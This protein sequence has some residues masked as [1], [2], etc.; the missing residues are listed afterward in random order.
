MG[1]KAI[2]FIGDQLK[3][4]LT[5]SEN[6]KELIHQL[7]SP[8]DAF[9]LCTN[10]KSNSR[11]FLYIAK[12]LLHAQKMYDTACQL[13]P[14][15]SVYFF[16]SDEFFNVELL[17]S[18]SEFKEAR[19]HTLLQT[20]STAP[21]I[22]ITYT[23]SAF[24]PLVPKKIFFDN[25]VTLKTEDEISMDELTKRL[26]TLGYT[27]ATTVEHIGQYAVRG[28]LIDIYPSG[29]PNPLRIEFFG[30]E[31][32]SIR[33][34]S[35]T[36]QKT[37]KVITSNITIIPINEMLL[38]QEDNQKLLNHITTTA[39]QQQH[40]YTKSEDAKT[41]EDTITSEI[42]NISSYTSLDKHL[43]Y[44]NKIYPTPATIFDYIDNPIVFMQDYK[45]IK[46]AYD[47]IQTDSANMQV[48]MLA[49]GKLL[50]S[51]DYLVDFN[52][53]TNKFTDCIYLEHTFP[54]NKLT[55]SKVTEQ[56]ARA[57]TKYQG[58]LELFCEDISYLCKNQAVVLTAKNEQQ[59]ARFQ[60]LLKEKN[61]KLTNI[62]D[63]ILPLDKGVYILQSDLL[64]GVSF[65]KRHITL[66]SYNDTFSESDTPLKSDNYR[67]KYKDAIKLK[68]FDDLK[69]GDYV[70]HETH[71]IGQYLGIETINAENANKDFLKI[72][73][74]GTDVLYVPVDKFN[75]VQKYI[76]REGVK[77]KMH[78]LGSTTWTRT[79]QSVKKKI[80]DIAD[81]LVKLYLTRE[82]QKG[83]KFDKDSSLQREFEEKFEYTET[84][85]QLKAINDVKE[86]MESE[87][88]MDR[89]VCGDVG[90]GK[91]EVA[92]RAAFKAVI[93]GKQVAYLAPTT[94]LTYQHYKTF[95]TRLKDYPIRVG[96]LNR[97]VSPKEIKETIQKLKLGQL[98]IVIGT[99]RILSKDIEF[100]DLGLLII[101]EE[102]RFGVLHK[103]R[104]KELKTSVDVLTL[105][106]TPIPRTLQMSLVGIRDLSTINTPPKNRYP[107]QTYVSEDN[108]HII[109]NAIEREIA[110]N[111]QVIYLHNLTSD[112]DIKA[113]KI[114]KLVPDAKV[115][116]AHG[117]M[118]KNELEQ[119]VLDFTNGKYQVLV[120]TTIIETGIDIPT[121][122]TLIVSG[123]DRLGLSQLYQ[124][125]GRVGRSNKIAYAYFMYKQNKILS[126]IATKRLDTIRDFTELGS[127][128]KI[129]MQD[130][131]IR[132]A[133]DM[134]GAEQSGFI[135]SVGFNMYNQMLKDAVTEAKEN[136]VN[137][138]D[139][140]QSVNETIDNNVVAPS[141][142]SPL[143]SSSVDF[144]LKWDA[145]IPSSFINDESIKIDLY[146]RIQVIDTLDDYNEIQKEITDRFGAFPK[147]VNFLLT[148][149]FAHNVAVR[150]DIL[151]VVESK[152]FIEIVL[153]KKLSSKLDGN[154]L[155]NMGND[156][157]KHIRFK[158]QNEKIIVYIDK[159]SP[160]DKNDLLSVLLQIEDLSINGV[161][162][163]KRLPNIEHYI[164]KKS[165]VST[166]KLGQSKKGRYVRFDQLSQNS[167]SSQA[168][169]KMSF[170]KTSESQ[171][172]TVTV[173][174]TP[175]SPKKMTF[176]SKRQK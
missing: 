126:E 152:T 54:T 37:I 146:K 133:G 92:L 65:P 125:R 55:V 25:L 5:S 75:L 45:H 57:I 53:L 27:P 32:D 164:Q 149:F 160:Y 170:R 62:D 61:I 56:T 11:N 41:F 112:I 136:N 39:K 168:T 113:S 44:L 115:A 49:H 66:I 163:L 31:I 6:N 72:A 108:D 173:T 132:G 174:K 40:K 48:D 82:R 29:Y 148:A 104:I 18:S 109:K 120:C 143:D 117:K 38:S 23:A 114:A 80:S 119:T 134:I 50:H 13:L 10:F 145:Y 73:Y 156:I 86:D 21:K 144:Q 151:K 70:V 106:A 95:K 172:S 154:K 110:R 3:L 42:S 171:L 130:L 118:H 16:P 68:T 105:T 71:G 167:S 135:T 142:D 85:D 161:I 77:P 122:N 153:S 158:Y 83:Y 96:L 103:E 28:G 137:L 157:G 34:F 99:H 26:V 63:I 59:L 20:K 116:F 91:T 51:F 74:Q 22:Y 165:N 98:D 81:R 52:D 14:K 102:Q 155:F 107:I 124:I 60:S 140:N 12:N 139:N 84:V 46:F 43:K 89:L 101:D 141:G 2:K 159:V 69:I 150:L 121:A 47:E 129:A 128:F 147:E 123:A 127:G 90:Y 17:A 79:K 15:D 64:T 162:T 30:D 76:G 35:V 9:L 176:G 131:A 111:G 88:A 4:N 33:E 138:V 67:T 100:K 78:R 7:S 97:F 19:I 87:N 1:N 175:T 166:I 93:S 94:L 169:N 36:D 24:R 8:V 58:N